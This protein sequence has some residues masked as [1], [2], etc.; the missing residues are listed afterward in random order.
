MYYIPNYIFET[1]KFPPVLP[2]AKITLH[3]EFWDN[4]KGELIKIS[5]VKFKCFE[6]NA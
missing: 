1:D 5:E 3:I 2:E 6:E 4:I